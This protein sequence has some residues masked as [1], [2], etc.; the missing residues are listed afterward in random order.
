[1]PTDEEPGTPEEPAPSGP[2]DAGP[3]PDAGGPTEGEEQ[4]T[5]FGVEPP[6]LGPGMIRE[7]PKPQ[8]GLPTESPPE[9]ASEPPSQSGQDESSES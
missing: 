3:A 1:M 6:Y 8:P 7:A 9:P 4:A 5:L 2:P